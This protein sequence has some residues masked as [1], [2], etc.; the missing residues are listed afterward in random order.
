MKI[1][2]IVDR[3]IILRL[4]GEHGLDV[5]KELKAFEN[6]IK[7]V[8]EEL[9]QKLYEINARMWEIE[10]MA[11]LGGDGLEDMGRLFHKQRELNKTRVA[12]KNEIA[13]YFKEVEEQ[14]LFV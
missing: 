5:S 4:K 10:D 8:P 12:I 3:Y 1:A 11:E 7:D 6:E 13:R 9:L 2:E 14:K